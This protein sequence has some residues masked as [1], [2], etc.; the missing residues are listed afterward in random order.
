MYL[1]NGIDHI[2]NLPTDFF[3]N[4]KLD[5]DSLTT[6]RINNAK[7]VSETLGNKPA[8]LLSGGVDSQ[9][10]VQ[11]W[12]EA[13]L[14]FDVVAFRFKNDLNIQDFNYAVQYC[15]IKN[16]NYVEIDFDV[17]TFLNRENF[18]IGIKYNSVSP[19]FNVHYKMAEI[20][21]DMG[22]TGIC[23]GGFA[24]ILINGDWGTNYSYNTCRYTTVSEKLG[25]PLQGNF[26]SYTPELAWSIALLTQT[27]EAKLHPDIMND[28]FELYNEQ[29]YETKIKGYELSGFNL[30]PQPQKF[31]GFELV[32]KHYEKLTRDPWT[33]DRTFRHSLQNLLKHNDVHL[34]KINLSHEQLEQIK[35]I[36]YKNF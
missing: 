18:N 10:M 22:Y 12:A 7:L 6:Y 13:N 33:F 15:K 27:F 1:C 14:Q 2:V 9:A 35:S 25:I 8:V 31:T 21:K 29:R 11:C 34:Y 30:I 17:I 4:L 26:L 24:P 32:K 20:L 3:K 36:Q 28:E 19:H 23:C 5:S 16:L